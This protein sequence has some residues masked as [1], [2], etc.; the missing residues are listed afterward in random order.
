MRPYDE[1]LLGTAMSTVGKAFD[2]ADK[3]LPGGMERFYDLFV[4]S[5]AARTFDGPDAHPTSAR[6]A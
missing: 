1:K 3:H 5:A 6:P 4:T 2:F